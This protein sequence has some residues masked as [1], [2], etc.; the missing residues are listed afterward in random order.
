MGAGGSPEALAHG[1]GLNRRT[2]YRWLAAYQAGGEA[3]LYAKPIRGARPKLTAKQLAKLSPLVWTKN[4][5]QLQFEFALWPW[6]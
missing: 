3:A 6:P 4:P 5:L 2:I 1:L